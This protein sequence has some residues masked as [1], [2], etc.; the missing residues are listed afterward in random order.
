MPPTRNADMPF[1]PCQYCRR[2]SIGQMLSLK[3]HCV[4]FERLKSTVFIRH[5]QCCKVLHQDGHRMKKDFIQMTLIMVIIMKLVMVSIILSV[6]CMHS[7]MPSNNRAIYLQDIR[8]DE[9]P[10]ESHTSSIPAAN[11]RNLGHEETDHRSIETA[12]EDSNKKV[13]FTKVVKKLD[14]V[15]CAICLP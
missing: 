13:I 3:F 1:V 7:L 2:I 8:L 11:H 10:Y 4:P 6:T 5:T 12:L 15:I 14:V 9:R